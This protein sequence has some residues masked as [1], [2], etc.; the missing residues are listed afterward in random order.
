MNFLK[1]ANS[2][3]QWNNLLII[4]LFDKISKYETNETEFPTYISEN[5]YNDA[6]VGE[7]SSF[8]KLLNKI[9]FYFAIFLEIQKYCLARCFIRPK[10]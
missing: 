10:P 9:K 2:T 8:W 4:K 7:N 3:I 1:A 6:S 5:S